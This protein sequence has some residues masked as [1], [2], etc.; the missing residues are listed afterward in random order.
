MSELSKSIS[1]LI[2]VIAVKTGEDGKMFGDRDR[3]H[4]GR[5]IEDAIRHRA[6]QEENSS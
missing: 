5:P 4:D 6:G 2:A 3:G 1:K